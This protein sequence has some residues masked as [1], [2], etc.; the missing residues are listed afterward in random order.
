MVSKL[1]FA[2]HA[3]SA[4]IIALAL[5]GC[6]GDEEAP[7]AA[8]GAS[9]ESPAATPAAP[10][11]EAVLAPVQERMI[12]R[13]PMQA[14]G[15]LE[16]APEARRTN[17]MTMYYSLCRDEPTPEMLEA[18]GIPSMARAGIFMM[19]NKLAA[20]ES[21]E[22]TARLLSGMQQVRSRMPTFEFIAPNVANVHVGG[23]IKAA[24]FTISNERAESITITVVEE[25]DTDGP[26]TFVVTMEGNDLL[27]LTNPAEPDGGIIILAREGTDDP[28]NEPHVSAVPAGQAVPPALVGRWNADGEHGIDTEFRADK[29]YILHGTSPLEGHFWVS[30]ANGNDITIRTQVGPLPHQLADTIEISIDG[31]T[32]NWHNVGTDSRT[33]YTRL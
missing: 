8:E 7:A 30:S 26:E 33:T 16:A 11:P 32:L 24:T 29:A 2:G 12:G 31:T 23:Q 22:G 10:A 25:N 18:A 21:D 20:G 28:M 3:V 4:L 27:R 13:W 14:R 15:A 1:R 9:T 5:V 6:G 17:T 19:R